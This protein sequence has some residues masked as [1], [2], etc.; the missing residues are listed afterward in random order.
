MDAAR[1]FRVA[2]VFRGAGAPCVGLS[3]HG[4]GRW[5]VAA[6]G[7]GVVRVLDGLRGVLRKEVRCAARGVGAACFGHAELCV[8][9]ADAAPGTGVR[10]LSLHDNRY[11]RA[12]EGH[13]APVCGLA[14]SPASDAFFSLG[15]DGTCV[16]WD[17]AQRRAAVARLDVFGA[18]ASRRPRHAPVAAFARDALVF[19]AGAAFADARGGGALALYDAR[20]Y[21]AGPFATFR[22]DRGALAAVAAPEAAARA[23]RGRWARLEFA[24]DG[25]TLLV[26]GEAGVHTLLDAFEGDALAAFAAPPSAAGGERAAA[27]AAA[28]APGGGAVLAGGGDGVLRAW[29]PAA[30]RRPCAALPAGHAGPVARIACSPRFGVVATACANTALWLADA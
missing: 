5:C 25:E 18:D 22:V 15:E 9:V 8:V 29:D 6:T 2:Q 13:A 21:R 7:D 10:Y 20:H 11:L 28:F 16:L 14:P 3:F 23:A 4:G 17:A 30:P 24:P 19:A 1:K 27:A 26:A 12:F